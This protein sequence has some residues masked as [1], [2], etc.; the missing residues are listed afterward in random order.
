MSKGVDAE[1]DTTFD[2]VISSRVFQFPS[3]LREATEKFQNSGIETSAL[4]QQV[5]FLRQRFQNGNISR[6]LCEKLYQEWIITSVLMIYSEGTFLSIE[7]LLTPHNLYLKDLQS[8]FSEDGN[9]RSGTLLSGKRKL[10]ESVIDGNKVTNGLN[11][12]F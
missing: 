3:L 6:Y 10:A 12:L 8:I 9:E 1:S 4:V 2:D 7:K 11:F 5:C